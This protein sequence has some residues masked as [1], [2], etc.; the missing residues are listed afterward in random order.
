[1]PRSKNTTASIMLGDFHERRRWNEKFAAKWGRHDAWKW[2]K[3]KKLLVRCPK[4]KSN[5]Y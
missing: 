5:K 2:A 4:S 3:S 1:M